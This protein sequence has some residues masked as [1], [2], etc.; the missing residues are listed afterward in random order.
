MQE[1]DPGNYLCPST[2]HQQ[3]SAP[4]II[5]RSASSTTS[6]YRLCNRVSRH[7]R[8]LAE[9]FRSK[10][11]PWRS[12]NNGMFHKLQQFTPNIDLVRHM[13]AVHKNTP[14]RRPPIKKC[15][16]ICGCFLRKQ[17]N[18]LSHQQLICR[19][20]RRMLAFRHI[21]CGRLLK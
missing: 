5:A 10:P 16:T 11:R 14:D 13:D 21:R 18:T 20:K 17:T 4:I 15:I 12:P 9:I 1:G 8:L 19:K 6:L 7:G 2:K 3:N